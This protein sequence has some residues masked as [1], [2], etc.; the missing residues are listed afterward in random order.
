MTRQPRS[1]PRD[2]ARPAPRATFEDVT[3]LIAEQQKYVD[4]I[5]ALDAKRAQTP[6][7]VFTRVHADYEE[8]LRAVVEKLAAHRGTIEEERS[9]LG[10]KL[11]NVDEEARRLRDERAEIELRGHVGELSESAA[12]ESLRATDTKLDQLD[13]QRRGIEED[14]FRVTAFF[15]ATAGGAAPAPTGSA[16]PRTSRTSFD[17]LSFLQSVVGPEEAGTPGGTEPAESTPAAPAPPSETARP[18]EPAQRAATPSGAFELERE[19]APRL[20]SKKEA[21]P[22]AE[23]EPAVEKKVEARVKPRVEPKA[24][25]PPAPPARTSVEKPAPPPPSDI[26]IE[27]AIE[28][29]PVAPA[30][31]SI[32][33]QQASMTIEPSD[34]QRMSGIVKDEPKKGSLLDGITPSSGKGEQPFAA[35]VASNN[36]MSLKSGAP[37]DL[38][39]LKCRDCGSMNDPSEWYCERCG[40]ELSA[41]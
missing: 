17:E 26:Q 15:A 27:K 36:P 38:K 20:E 24:A 4:W 32:A 2:V 23:P 41:M 40:A 8:R 29:S 33:M 10:R 22:E 5:A 13:K 37:S 9:A 6:E 1:T 19:D 39:T 11:S 18:P 35:N 34:V 3:S 7:H 16:A 31:L 30:R 28:L 21:K 25:E 12:A 14:L